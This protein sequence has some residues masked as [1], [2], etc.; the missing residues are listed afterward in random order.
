MIVVG[1]WTAILAWGMFCFGVVVGAASAVRSASDKLAEAERVRDET[2]RLLAEMRRDNEETAAH[3]Q[4]AEASMGRTSD[5]VDAMLA[6]I[7]NRKSEE[8]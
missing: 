6:T 2:D 8:T 4:N 7:E 5:M 1:F 3:L